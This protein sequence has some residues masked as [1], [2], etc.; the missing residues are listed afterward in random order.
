MRMKAKGLQS[1]SLVGRYVDVILLAGMATCKTT[2][3]SE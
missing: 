3:L 2:L 1:Q